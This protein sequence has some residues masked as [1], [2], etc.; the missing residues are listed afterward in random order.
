M[1]ADA[2]FKWQEAEKWAR[3]SGGGIAVVSLD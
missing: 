1:R 3:K 2:V